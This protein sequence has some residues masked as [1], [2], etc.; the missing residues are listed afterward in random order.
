MAD[1]PGRGRDH[2]PGWRFGGW[3]L[4]VKDGSAKFVYNLLGM[5]QFAT[6]ATEPIPAGS[7]RY[8]WS[9]PTTAAAW[10][11]AA[12][13]RSTT[14]ARPSGRAASKQTQPLIFSADET[15]DIGDDYGMPV[16]ADYAATTAVQRPHRRRPDRHRR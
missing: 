1:D 5:Q 14:T 4:Y 15:T 10:P 3:A 16:T 12:M 9:S 6:E 11:K 8:G 2:R 13:S 7:T